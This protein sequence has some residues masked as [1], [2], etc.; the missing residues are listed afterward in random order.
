MSS[1]R[2]QVTL[3]VVG[4]VAIHLIVL[5]AWAF[6]VQ[7]FPAA[8]AASNPP[9]EQIKLQVV[10]ENPDTPPPPPEPVLAPKPT[11]FTPI[12]LSEREEP[13]DASHPPKDTAFQSD[14]DSEAASELPASGDKPLPTR[15]GKTVPH[16]AFDPQPPSPGDA[17]DTAGQNVAENMPPSLRVT[18]PPLPRPVST[19]PPAPSTPP[20]SAPPADPRD[21]AMVTPQ[22]IPATP[23]DPDPNPYDPSIRPPANMTEP[24]RPTPVPRR[25][26]GYRPLQ[27]RTASAGSVDNPGTSSVA[28]EAT[29]S[30]RYTAS[31]IQAIKRR[32]YQY[33]DAR[34]DVV[35]L[36]TVRIHFAVD[37]DG[38][39]RTPRIVSNTANEALASISLRALADAPIPP[40]PDDVVASTSGAQLPIDIYFNSEAPAF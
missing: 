3:A 35:S 33:F 8:Q 32:W 20:P 28:A 22:S 17:G 29:P 38:K 27:E 6:A 14:R 30:G 40:M 23:A 10:A 19:P 5:F 31:V 9:P 26:G 11:P 34:A 25:G 13:P 7:W 21:L 12:V 39:I 37:R 1:K 24:P 16:F 18:A 4:S 36:G 15:E 2:K